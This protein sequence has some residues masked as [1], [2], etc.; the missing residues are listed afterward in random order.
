MRPSLR[1]FVAALLLAP[2]LFIA[3]CSGCEEPDDEQAI[4]ALIAEG[5]AAAE[6]SD[7]GGLMELATD[8][9]TAEPGSASRQEVK[10]VL[11]MAFRR[12]GRFTIAHPSP[13][14]TIAEDRR[15]ATAELPFLVVRE[16][17]A[18]PDLGELVDDPERWFEGVAEMGDAFYL[19]LRLE[20]TDDG[21][22]AA[23]ARIKGTRGRFS[24]EP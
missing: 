19:T 15:S 4:R 2:P 18:A 9:F 22:K 17:S 20:K 1:K 6:R 23:K 14:V 11:L 21:W 5:A 13:A 24:L 10:G 3:S 12:Y 7:V 8:G 16:G